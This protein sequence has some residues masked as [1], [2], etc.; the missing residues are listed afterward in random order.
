[1]NMADPKKPETSPTPD[2]VPTTVQTPV[3]NGSK[4]ITPVPVGQ[5]MLH[6]HLNLWID[7]KND[8]P[9]DDS[10]IQVQI[11]AGKLTV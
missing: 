5:P 3:I 7:G 1:M 10:F 6:L 2:P 11:E 9:S 8:F 4:R